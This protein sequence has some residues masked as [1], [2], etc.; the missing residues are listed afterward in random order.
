MTDEELNPIQQ[1][2]ADN[3]RRVQALGQGRHGAPI[4]IH[5]QQ[6]MELRI[7]SYLEHLAGKLTMDG[8]EEMQLA[9]EEKLA[10]TLDNLEQQSATLKLTHGVGGAVPPDMFPPGSPKMN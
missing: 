9:F 3:L 4:Q 5:P 7:I 2:S 1:A 8:A 10:E 6:L